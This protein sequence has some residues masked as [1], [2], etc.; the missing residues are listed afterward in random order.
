MRKK[1]YLCTRF[2][3]FKKYEVMRK[4]IMCAIMAL[5]IGCSFTS[6]H[7]SNEE[8]IS[9]TDT[10]MVDSINIDSINAD[11]LDVCSCFMECE[12]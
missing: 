1:Y 3:D 12:D 6:C 10:T 8:S 5:V 11:T 9:N 7:S 2:I 4:F